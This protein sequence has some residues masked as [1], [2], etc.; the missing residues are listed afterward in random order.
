VRR[1]VRPGYDGPEIRTNVLDVTRTYVALDIET[2]GLD[3]ERDRIT[4]VAAVRFCPERGPLDTFSTLVR[5]DRPIP[6]FIEQLTGITNDAVAAAPSLSEV[7]DDL[8]RFVGQGPVVGQNVGFDLGY[9]RR[10]G[11]YLA[12]PAVDTAELSRLLMPD[13]QPRG[14]LGLASAL[15]VEAGEHHRALPDAHT[16]AAVFSALRR[17]ADALDPALRL[18]LARLVGMHDM[19][20][21][22]CIAGEGW[23]S[24]PA[25]ERAVPGVRP[26]PTFVPLVRAEPQQPVHR[27]EVTYAFRAAEGVIEGFEHRA[28]QVRM[29]ETVAG[30]L[31]DGG[32]WLVEAGTGV[33]KSLA[34]L[35][36]AALFALRN[37]ERVVV[38]TN[39]INLQEQLLTKD[40]PALRRILRAAGV[41]A[42]DAD[43]R[44]SVLKGRGNYLCLRRWVASYGANLGDPDFARLG[45]AMLLWLPQTETGDRSELSLGQQEWVTWQRFSAQ[46]SDCLARPNAYTKDGTC[47]LQR[48]RRAAESAHIVIVNHAL[49]LADIAASGS[50]LPPFD[51]LV[52]DE[53]H[54]LEEQATQ[55]FGGSVSRRA[56]SEAL[57]GIHRRAGRDE[58]EGGVVSLLKALP[59]GA[60]RYAGEALE[61]AVVAALPTVAPPFEALAKLLP[62]GPDDDR[63]LVSRA[64]RAREQWT[65][66]ELA[67]EKLDRALRRVREAADHA[68][69]TVSSTAL[70]E[71]PDV[72]AGEIESA[73]RKVEDL[74]RLL[75]DLVAEQGDDLIVWAGRERDGTGSLNSAPLDVGPTLW[76]NLLSKKRTVV[77]TSATLAA[78]GSMDFAARRLGFERPE[79]LQLG[80]PFDYERSTLLAALTDVPEPN[81]QGWEQAVARTVVELVS[82]SQG[83]ALVLFTSHAALRRVAG[84]VRPH[85]EEAG[86]VLLAQGVDGPP[87]QLTENLM[88]NPR[89]AIF[90]TSSFWEGVDVRGDAL[91][92]LVL[93]RLPFAVPSDPVHRARS[94]QYENAFAQYSLPWAILR[95]RQGFG[96]LIRHRDDRGIVAVLDRRI[97]ERQYGTEFVRALPRCTRLKAD[98][99]TVAARVREWLAR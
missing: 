89:T 11:V 62:P 32:H 75:G 33:G 91:S 17:K 20:L 58:R 3:P 51:H 70:V 85:L 23:R 59:E 1:S 14:L 73:A 84:L 21:A 44:V 50:A 28:E 35:L 48:A 86:I 7:A 46:D 67:W 60:S 45:A 69:R 55:Q 93:T 18:Q 43:L 19:A 36:P 6:Y 49:L 77:A 54:N 25:G 16:A 5:P 2:T 13:R 27:Q 83:R 9:L 39:T 74:R 22:E 40:V 29:A 8:V 78:A 66:V 92:L 95:F 47:F 31:S 99:A 96:R 64:V 38:S 24:I 82:A 41:I 10:E 42:D 61:E 90:G 34:Y 63:L 68:S 97:Y 65:E 37:G 88:A 52:V 12:A 56:V 80:S 98:T 94:E 81:Q 72:L 71:E 79:T 30:A 53:A 76:E 15:E 26:A 57:D 4:E 87:R